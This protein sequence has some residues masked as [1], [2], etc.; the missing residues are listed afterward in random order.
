MRFKF[1][2]YSFHKRHCEEE[3]RGNLV[4]NRQDCRASL[5]MT[6]NRRQGVHLIPGIKMPYGSH[7]KEKP[8]I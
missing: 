5:A 4:Y 6:D 2:V 8:G 1:V 7:E 3:R